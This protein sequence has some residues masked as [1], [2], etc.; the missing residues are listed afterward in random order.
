VI[1]LNGMATED[2]GELTFSTM[3]YAA[4]LC[5]HDHHYDRLV[6]DLETAPFVFVGTTLDEVILWQHMELHRRRNRA[7]P[8]ARGS[9]LVSPALSRARREL[10]ASIGITWIRGTAAE[11]A[12]AS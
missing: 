1:H 6:T 4:R 3:Q 9:F 8:A 5:A 11:L 2:G 10:L 12:P 7:W